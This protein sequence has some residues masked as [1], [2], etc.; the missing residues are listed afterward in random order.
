MGCSVGQGLVKSSNGVQLGISSAVVQIE[1]G[2]IG[3]ENMPLTDHEVGKVT[4]S[5]I[6][7][8]LHSR[9]HAC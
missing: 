2:K 5:F 1:D 3:A 4:I 8:E 7:Y 6:L 9:C